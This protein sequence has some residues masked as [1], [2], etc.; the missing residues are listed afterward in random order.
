M[1]TNRDLPTINQLQESAGIR[2]VIGAVSSELN[3][4]SR[5]TKKMSIYL[6]HRF[7]GHSLKEIGENF[8]IGESAVSETSN[9]FAEILHADQRLAETVARLLSTLNL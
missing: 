8:G 4:D 7:S 6:C 1:S 9:R 2:A 3:D 5:M